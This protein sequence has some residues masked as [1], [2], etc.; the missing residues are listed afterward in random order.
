MF[1][2]TLFHGIESSVETGDGHFWGSK[3]WSGSMFSTTFFA[4]R[5]VAAPVIA[6]GCSPQRQ[7][8]P[9]IDDGDS[10]EEESLFALGEI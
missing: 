3:F 4:G 6:P 2:T 10:D 9:I 7:R 8:L 5:R 1:G